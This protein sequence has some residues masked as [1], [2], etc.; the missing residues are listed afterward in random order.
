MQQ[1]I[2]DIPQLLRQIDIVGVRI[3]KP[4]DLVPEC[5]D[6]LGAVFLNFIQLRQLIDQF[7]VFENRHK[8]FLRREIIDL[9]ALPCRL[10]IENLQITAVIDCL[11]IDTQIVGDG[12]AGIIDEE[13]IDLFKV[14]VCDLADVLADLDLGDDIAVLVLHC[15]ELI[16]AA[17]DRLA[18]GGNETLTDAEGAEIRVALRADEGA[19]PFGRYDFSR[20][21]DCV[22][23]SNDG[24]D[25]ATGSWYYAS[26]KAVAPIVGGVLDLSRVPGNKPSDTSYRVQVAFEDDHS[27]AFG[28]TA[29]Y[30]GA[31]TLEGVDATPD[32][33]TTYCYAGASGFYADDG[34]NSWGIDFDNADFTHLLSIFEFN[35]A[36]D[37]TEQDGIPAGIYTITEDYAPNTVTWA[38][39]DEEMT[40]LSTGTVTVERD[41]E[42]Y[43]V[44]VDAVDEYDAP[45]KADFAGQIYYENTSEQAS[46]SPREV[47][48]VCYGEKDGLTNWYITLVDR[49]YLTTRDAVGNCYYGSIL[50]FDL[51]SD[52]A[53]DY[54][55]GVPEGT[56]AVRNGQSGVGIWGGD[57]A[58]CTS[59]LAEY[60]SGSP[61]IGKLTEGNV[62]IAR[63]GEWYEISFDGLTLAGSDQTSLTGSYEGR[64]QYIDARE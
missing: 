61:A 3:V 14:R 43:K 52:A 33:T 57:N 49:G 1:P 56:F 34:Y 31:M 24:A 38:T 13:A 28:I 26:Q 48:V 46:I 32:A 30:S 18:L 62:T 19:S 39:Y 44:T 60:F 7:A 8:Q 29:V 35:V 42:E 27:P 6:L 23:G 64:V 55:D 11:I 20:A 25:A 22:P 10:R 47:Y 2:L 5:I 16:D 51:R 41:G 50:H 9:F 63:D 21:N 37:A 54:A 59:F 15:D 45:F 36:P 12:L 17:E 58:A 4:F 40:Y 53:N